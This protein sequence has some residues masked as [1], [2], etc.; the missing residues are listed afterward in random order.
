MS[1]SGQI[2]TCLHRFEIG[3][4]GAIET[5]KAESR[6][7]LWTSSDQARPAKYTSVQNISATAEFEV[8]C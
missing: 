5:W 8:A 1:G 2:M 3:E 7:K 4:V 6:L